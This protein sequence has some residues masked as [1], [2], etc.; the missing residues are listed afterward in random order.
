MLN[1]DG[2]LVPFDIFVPMWVDNSNSG[3]PEGYR[4][5]FQDLPIRSTQINWPQFVIEAINV[6]PSP[7]GNVRL[8]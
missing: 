8:E 6:E 2:Q 3:L 7:Q 4:I 5:I 1:I